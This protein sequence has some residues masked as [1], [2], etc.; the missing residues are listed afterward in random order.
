MKGWIAHWS[1]NWCLFRE[2]FRAVSQIWYLEAQLNSGQ[3]VQRCHEQWQIILGPQFCFQMSYSNGFYRFGI[4]LKKWEGAPLEHEALKKMSMIWCNTIWSL[5][6]WDWDC[7]SVP[8]LRP[9]I[10][11]TGG[12]FWW[13]CIHDWVPI[14]QLGR[15]PRLD[16]WKWFQT[17]HGYLEYNLQWNPRND[18][19]V[20][21]LKVSTH[22]NLKQTS[23]ILGLGGSWVVVALKCIK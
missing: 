19:E 12:L 1:A 2:Q 14:A 21:S 20:M 7:F 5:L 23:K 22:L 8:S 9:V 13:P 11:W 3:D 15:G 17:G 16:A 6:F 4:Y 10:W 18:S